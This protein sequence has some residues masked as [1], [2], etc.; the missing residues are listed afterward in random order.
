MLRIVFVLALSAFISEQL[1]ATKGSLYNL[2][3]LLLLFALND[4]RFHVKSKWNALDAFNSRKICWKAIKANVDGG[5]A[6][7]IPLE[8]YAI[9]PS[10]FDIV[11]TNW[12][13]LVYID[14]ASCLLVFLLAQPEFPVIRSN[15]AMRFVVKHN[16][17]CANKFDILSLSILES[18]VIE[19]SF[20]DALI[21]YMAA[22]L[23]R[24]MSLP[25]FKYVR[26]DS[27]TFWAAAVGAKGM[28][29]V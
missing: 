5:A 24:Y 17:D 20:F 26:G 19:L 13:A 18:N 23:H 16:V 27:S 6:F 21:Y 8:R 11:D 12:P 22:N 14:C 7:S 28:E 2:M 1:N 10:G 15:F 29:S 25:L 4:V 9:E 3:L